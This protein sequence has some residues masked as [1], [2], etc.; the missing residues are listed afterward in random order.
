M[1]PAGA[2]LD[3][4]VDVRRVVLSALVSELDL[5]VGAASLPVGYVYVDDVVGC[6]VEDAR[7]C[8]GYVV[9]VAVDYAGGASGVY[10]ADV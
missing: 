3:F 8:E 10:Y 4:V 5:S 9:E 1:L 2:Y 6:L 7:V